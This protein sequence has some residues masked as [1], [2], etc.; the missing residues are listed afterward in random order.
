M[1][2]VDFKQAFDSINRI[3]L[4]KA[5]EDME[6]PPKIIRLIQTTLKKT[7][8]KVKLHNQVS[9]ELEFSTGVKQG[10]GLSTTLFILG[11][12]KTIEKIDQRGT[13][14]NKSS[15]ICA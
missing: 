7:M 5:M 4:L 9:N 6:I 13:I 11:L 3:K 2:F 10:D 15:Q 8:A 1:L 12:H 14:F